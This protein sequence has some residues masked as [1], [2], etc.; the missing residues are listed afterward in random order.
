[1]RW[2]IPGLVVLVA[3]LVPTDA[4]AWGPF[5]HLLLSRTVAGAPGLLP[6]GVAP[7][8]TA[9]AAEFSYGSLAADIVIGKNLASYVQHAHN[10][11]NVF[12]LLRTAETPAER[13]FGLGY[14]TH[15]AADTVA[16]NYFIPFKLVESYP[17]T[18]LKHT[19]WEARFDKRSYPL[20]AEAAGELMGRSFPECDRLHEQCIAGT[21]FR[22]RTNKRI[23]DSVFLFQSLARWQR[24]VAG[25]EQRSP[26]ALTPEERRELIDLSLGAIRAFLWKL[27][28]SPVTR[29]DPRGD[30]AIRQAR[31]LRRELKRLLRRGALRADQMRPVGEYFRPAFRAA[32]EQPHI[33]VPG[34]VPLLTR[35]RQSDEAARA[36]GEHVPTNRRPVLRRMVEAVRGARGGRPRRPEP[37]HPGAVVQQLAPADAGATGPGRAR[38]LARL[39]DLLRRRAQSGPDGPAPHGPRT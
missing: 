36:R 18:F 14:L 7:I 5:T 13:A 15:L 38:A 28:E 33:Q 21:L 24:A 34:F 16:H 20:V 19:Y 17:A 26:F 9:F 39:R 8:I 23:F 11:Q 30:E 12:R 35:L 3:L 22:F 37:E 4:F 25:I 31:N 2:L 1:M 29:L 6:P 32:A 10:W 27:E